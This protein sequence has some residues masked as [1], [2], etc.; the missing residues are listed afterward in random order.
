MPGMRKEQSMPKRICT[1]LLFASALVFVALYTCEIVSA[2]CT[3]VPTLK[4]GLL[5]GGVCCP[6]EDS[7]LCINAFGLTIEVIPDANGNWP[8]VH[9]NDGNCPF[10]CVTDSNGDIAANCPSCKEF[11]YRAT[12]SNTSGTYSGDFN[13]LLPECAGNPVANYIPTGYGTAQVNP[14]TTG[15]SLGAFGSQELWQ[16]TISMVDGQSQQDFSIWAVDGIL[17]NNVT[18]DTGT[19]CS[20]LV[21]I[22]QAGECAVAGIRGPTCPSNFSTDTERTFVSS[23]GLR[24]VVAE[25]DSCNGQVE[26]VFTPQTP[27]TVPPQALTYWGTTQPMWICY[28]ETGSNPP[29]IDPSTCLT[30]DSFGNASGVLIDL[31]VPA[32]K[33]PTYNYISYFCVGNVCYQK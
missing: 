2:Q 13:I 15:C 9:L 8:V 6:G 16:V 31:Q 20:S 25:Y 26:D 30:V 18:A 5:G 23:D 24:T 11:H 1:V 17:T 14:S 12:R 32:T 33:T 21:E 22:E 27:L 28:P 7:S 3:T 10:S 4:N 19:N 29:V